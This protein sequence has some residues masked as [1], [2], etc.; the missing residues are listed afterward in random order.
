MKMSCL[1]QSIVTMAC[2]L[3]L[4]VTCI[5]QDTQALS[6]GQ[7]IWDDAPAE[8]WDLAYPVGNGRLG[9]VVFGQ[10]PRE[11]IVLNEE[12]IW[13]KKPRGHMPADSFAHLEKI[14][15][16][17]A[18]GRYAEASDYFRTHLQQ[19][20]YR[21]SSYQ[22]LGE[23]SVEHLNA[24]APAK[25]YRDLNLETA[26]ASSTVSLPN[27]QIQQV[28]YA[29]IADDVVV[30]H[31]T[32]T[33]PQGLQL[34]V[35]LARK[36][37]QSRVEEKD[38]V[39]E[40][41][42]NG[43]GTRYHGR[44]RLRH[45]GGTVAAQPGCFAVNG[46]KAVTLLISAVTDF[47]R[48]HV[49]HPLEGPWSRRAKQ[50]L[51]GL[52]NKAE[53][54]LRADAVARYQKM[55][56]R[57]RLDLGRTD[58]AILKRPT[59]QRLAR[60]KDGHEDDTDLV[61]SYFHFGRYLLIASSQPGTFPANLQGIWNP[62]LEAPWNSDFHLNINIQMNYWLAETCNLSECHLPLFDLIKHF[63]PH[64]RQMAQR[65]GFEGWCM[66]HATDIWGHARI[67]SAQPFWGGSFFGGQWMT[68]HVLEH[69]RFTLDRD[70]LRDQ[71]P[72]LTESVKFVLSWLIR[73]PKTDQLICRPACSP[74]NSFLCENA[75]GQEVRASISAGTSFDQYMVMQV[76]ADYLEAAR[77]LGKLD[78]TYALRARKAL[79]N[80]YRPKIGPDGRLMEWRHPFKEAEPGH[81]H[82]S[83]VLGAYPGN[84]IDL[85]SDSKMRGA[86]EKT[87]QARLQ[88]GGAATG[89][90]RAWTIGMFARLA[91]GQEAYANLMA[92]LRRSTLE[93]LWDSHPPFQIDGNFGACAAVAEMLLH[94]HEIT[95][96]GHTVLRL[97][98]ALPRQW[99]S[100]SIRGLRARGGYEVS[101]AWEHN[102][103]NEAV[104]Q[105]RAQD[106]SVVLYLDQDQGLKQSIAKGTS[107]TYR[108]AQ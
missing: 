35:K 61:E 56:Q 96:E 78:E 65:M 84:Q 46:A 45:T 32:S 53:A 100:G 86:V 108:P 8:K 25:S 49:E 87:L 81:R 14:R 58:G 91:D 76:L 70:F 93:N 42:A 98:P 19:E 39:T 73:D 68:L 15:A 6:S 88:H 3:I 37:S 33:A 66:G 102:K 51:D 27:G 11:R 41:K 57:C 29:S 1:R 36:G 17:D 101:L 31:L 60:I 63:Q 7:L 92:I 23:L 95:P 9:A 85:A 52:D 72:V 16:L 4:P 79:D 21:P 94:S 18:Q 82:I 107:Y 90:S 106:G 71:W 104:I 34:R 44:V 89:W 20:G 48:H 83:H 50:I 99:R 97:L 38:L 2:S 77:A 55:A 67:M 62:H 69:Y 12:T 10:F 54:R 59:K 26:L 22:L 13:Q 24:P 74:E 105:A 43:K 64:G 103:L 75:S 30:V 47:N 80:C 28:V 5:A 40:G